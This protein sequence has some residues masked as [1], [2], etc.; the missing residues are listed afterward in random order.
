MRTLERFLLISRL[1]A[2]VDITNKTGIKYIKSSWRLLNINC[3][4]IL[5]S[6][7][8]PAVVAHA[9][10]PST[11]EAEAGRFLSLRSAWSTK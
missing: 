2:A 3:F 1:I 9:F 5:K 10:N 11:R 4:A 7:L 8:L 6:G